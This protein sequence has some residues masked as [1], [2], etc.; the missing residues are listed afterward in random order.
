[1]RD[2][3]RFTL[4]ARTMRVTFTAWLGPMRVEGHFG[5][6]HGALVLP[7]T[8]IE[9]ATLEVAVAAASIDTGI[10]ARTHTPG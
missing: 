3:T 2:A 6:L 8:D 5:E 7:N 4:D 10:A 9:R 1:M